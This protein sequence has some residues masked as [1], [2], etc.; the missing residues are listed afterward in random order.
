MVS[1]HTALYHRLPIILSTLN[2]AQRNDD[3][4]SP[5]P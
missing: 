1:V 5:P 4:Q 2:L 3:I